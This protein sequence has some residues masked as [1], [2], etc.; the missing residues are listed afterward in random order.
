MFRIFKK[1]LGIVTVEEKNSRIIVEGVPGYFIEKDIANAWK[2]SKLGNNMFIK[3][4]RSSFIIPSFFALDLRYMLE[5]MIE[6]T[7]RLD[8]SKRT[9]R[10]IV[11]RLNENTWLR[12]TLGD[13][14]GCLD[15]SKINNFTMTPLNFQ[16]EFLKY[17]DKLVPKYGLNGLM[18]A[19]AA[20]S[21]KTYTSL[22][23]AECLNSDHVIVVSPK[24]ALHKVWESNIKSVFK[25]PPSF[26][27]SDSGSLYQGQKIAVL[28]YEYLEKFL[29]E[30]GRMRGKI[31]II[32]DES[33]NLN[34]VTS[35]RTQLFIKLCKVTSSKN[36]I[37]ASG[38][39]IKALGSESIPIFTT[40]DP[41]FTDEVTDRFK[42]MFGRDA[43]K[44]I[45]ILANRIDLMSYK[46]EKSE[47]KLQ[48]PIIVNVPVKVPNGNDFTLEKVKEEMGV[49]IEERYQYYATRRKEDQKAYDECIQLYKDKLFSK[50][51]FEELELYHSYV[52]LM[53][54]A[55][56]RDIPEQIMWANK[57]ENSKIIP[58]LPDTHKKLFKEV[59]TIIKYTSL[60]IQGECLG[61]VLS[62]RRM[63]CILAMSEYIDYAKYIEST[64]KKTLIFTSYVDVL[65]HSKDVL[66]ERGFQPM[67]V[68]GKTNAE[69][70]KII[71][72]YE[73]DPAI[74]P[75]VA[76]FNSLS[77]A[78]PLTVADVMIMLNA[79]FR[80]Y[81]HQQAISR[82]HRLGANT[83]VY[84]YIAFLDT[85]D[86]PN[87]STRTIDI[88]AWSQA[89]VAAIMKIESPFKIDEL[90]V[91]VEDNS[92]KAEAIDWIDD[93]VYAENNLADPSLSLA[94]PAVE[95]ISA[96]A[97]W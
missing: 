20:G 12:Y 18:L 49:Y 14:P 3:V 92:D 58:F 44:S 73:T 31:T 8:M 15:F 63:E 52:K 33:H 50:E 36:V 45:D 25:N 21:G 7:G 6:N 22:V 46:I 94:E 57:Y 66:I 26:W 17:Y 83:Q 48:P 84:V 9:A 56:L 41:R 69:L 82:I 42:K 71:T 75:L 28:H 86:K 43:K 53:Q 88:L 65:E 97:K 37:W 85:G 91:G 62:K 27:L 24:N 29:L 11:D 59:K 47:L 54:T 13:P 61:R 55:S 70:N 89:A 19:G 67:V 39:S 38:T 74:N 1:A 51:Q 30:V 35:Q 78:V 23:L 87:L 77:T 96:I 64:E 34:E 32:L 10:Q 95:S 5:S 60:K 16:M 76:T 81:I 72:L 2:T 90:N 93:D 68:Y 4:T 79:P 40:I 80:D